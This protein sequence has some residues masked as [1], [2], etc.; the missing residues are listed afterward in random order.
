MLLGFSISACAQACNKRDFIKLVEDSNS[1]AEIM[2]HCSDLF[3]NKTKASSSLFSWLL[4][5]GKYD[6]VTIII[7][8]EPFY[9]SLSDG[10]KSIFLFDA[11]VADMHADK[12]FTL[13]IQHGANPNKSRL[14]NLGIVYDALERDKTK[15]LMKLKEQTSKQIYFEPQNI[16]AAIKSN[17]LDYA[18]EYF[19]FN[20]F[21][22]ITDENGYSM[23]D[24]INNHNTSF[25]LKQLVK[26]YTDKK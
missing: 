25:E 24:Y 2:R 1:A 13:L 10:E 4:R 19:R 9:E 16:F 17:N 15:L 20:G 7:K 12:L 21:I 26:N 18:K 6:L 8:D 14:D 3:S 11:M 23:L 5:V 22:N